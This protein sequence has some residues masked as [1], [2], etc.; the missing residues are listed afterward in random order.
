M[1]GSALRAVRAPHY[2]TSTVRL[3]A[4]KFVSWDRGYDASGKP[5]WGAV[6]GGYVFERRTDVPTDD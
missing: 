3:F 6:E 2:A 5:V 1:R 4:D